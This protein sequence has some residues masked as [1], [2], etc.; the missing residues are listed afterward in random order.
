MR[1]M[2]IVWDQPA[3]LIDLD[4]K[5]PVIGTIRDCVQHFTLF[6]PGAR[7]QA[8]M[9]LTRPVHREGRKTR[10]WLLEPAEIAVLAAR[11]ADEDPIAR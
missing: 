11:M 4:G 6:N 9:L 1:Q 5:T 7:E 10:T 2:D 3:T 8:R